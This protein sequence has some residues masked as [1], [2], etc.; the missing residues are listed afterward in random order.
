[1]KQNVYKWLLKKSGIILIPLLIIILINAGLSVVGVRFTMIAKDAVDVA[2]GQADGVL[3]SVFIKLGILIAFQIVLL[4][5]GTVLDSIVRGKFEIKLRRDLFNSL[6][7]KDWMSVSN[8]HSGELMNRINS[9]TYVIVSGICMFIPQFVSL[10]VTIILSAYYLFLLAPKFFVYI[11]PLVPVV[12][13][14]GRLYSIKIKK[15]H[16]NCQTADG[17]VRSFMQEMLQNI[18]AVKSFSAEDSVTEDSYNKQK[19]SYRFKLRR[20]I[21]S[22][23][24]GISIYLLFTVAYYGALAWGSVEISRGVITYGS[25]LAI[26]RLVSQI[27]SPL[28]SLSSVLSG[29]LASVASAER[30]IELENVPSEKLDVDYS[31]FYDRIN[32]VCIKGVSVSYGAGNILENADF[33]INNKEFVAVAG[34]SG[35]GKSTFLRLLLGLVKPKTGEIYLDGEDRIT[36]CEATR[37]YFSYVPQEN[38]IL[39]GTVRENIAFYRDVSNEELEKAVKVSCIDEFL[40][41]LPDGLDTILKEGG[42]GLSG[43]QIQRIAIARA[44]ISDSRCLLL[45]EATSALDGET[46]A[47]VLKN[48]REFTDKSCIIVSHRPAALEIC[49]RI[50]RFNNKKI[51]CDG[52]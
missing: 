46:E 40:S 22:A 9:D 27:Q 34:T 32:R 6:L 48:I 29:F 41:E 44:L 36:I 14:F 37:D 10:L 3:T 2:T 16:K 20:G 13:V 11:L 39:S 8:Y 47:H 26:L 45:D 24:A 17:V 23:F 19:Q 50:V 4:G 1:M 38:M 43:G 18:I 31:E 33:T 51:I 28:K 49:D 30:I 12:L 15:L 5:A 52:E 7:K 21:I 42:S 25:L 35:A